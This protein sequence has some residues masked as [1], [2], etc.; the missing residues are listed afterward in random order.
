MQCTH[1]CASA[2]GRRGRGARTDARQRVERIE[3]G[4][5][6]ALEV[7]GLADAH[8]EEDEEAE[9]EVVGE[10]GDERVPGSGEG[11]GSGSGSGSG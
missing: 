11:S 4:E 5:G 8:G 6:A 2:R 10:T 7:G 1:A 9:E 3:E